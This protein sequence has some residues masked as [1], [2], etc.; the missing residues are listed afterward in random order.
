MLIGKF[1]EYEVSNCTNRKIGAA[2]SDFCR[3]FYRA[4]LK[5]FP[6]RLSWFLCA[7]LFYTVEGMLLRDDLS[8]KVER[9][10]VPALNEIQ[11]ERHILVCNFDYFFGNQLELTISIPNRDKTCFVDC[12]K[13]SLLHL[14][15]FNRQKRQKGFSMLLIFIRH[16]AA[17]PV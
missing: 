17:P 16:G 7:P 1:V 8:Q 3:G 12:D 4:R 10:F 9:I 14:W 11:E 15:A 2:P 5:A 13:F 6:F